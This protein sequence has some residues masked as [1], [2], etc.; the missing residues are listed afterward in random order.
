MVIVKF[1]PLVKL[2][3][4]V[5]ETHTYIYMDMTEIFLAM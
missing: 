4:Q 2:M 5:A 3:A 1:V